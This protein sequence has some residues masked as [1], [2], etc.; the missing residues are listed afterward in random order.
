MRIQY[1]PYS[2][3][4]TSVIRRWLV[5]LLIITVYIVSQIQYVCSMLM[6]SLNLDT[7]HDIR[8]SYSLG[9]RA[10]I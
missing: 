10:G 3:V 8:K 9:F 7:C 6:L 4:C 1:K 2:T 5:V